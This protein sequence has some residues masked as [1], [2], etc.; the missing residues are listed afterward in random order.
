MTETQTKLLE[1]AIRTFVQYGVRKATM[2]DI[3]E[4]AAVSRPTLYASYRS[5]DE[6][7]GA[8]I[9]FMAEAS[10]EKAKK[11]WDKVDALD[12]KLDVYFENTV[13]PA[14]DLL[15]S[16]PSSDDLIS[17]H[18]AAGKAAI[19]ESRINARNALIDVLAPFESQIEYS[20]QSVSQFAHFV[21]ITAQGMKYTAGSKEELL[22]LLASL[23]A[24]V[25]SVTGG[26]FRRA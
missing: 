15:Q 12:R 25:L 22:D 24:A 20:G 2:L 4:E 23:K 26:E 3:A 17:G 13:I 8:C 10:L 16:S 21:V 9:R 6:I 18:N 1:A 7:L 19:L 11:A 14:F 5:K